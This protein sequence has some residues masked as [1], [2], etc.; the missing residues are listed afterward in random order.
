MD[1][2]HVKLAMFEET[3]SRRAYHDVGRLEWMEESGMKCA[4]VEK[5]KLM[6]WR[7]TNRALQAR[8]RA[9]PVDWELVRR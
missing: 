4:L 2:C 1:V 3:G 8:S 7:R 5:D 9:R 6:M